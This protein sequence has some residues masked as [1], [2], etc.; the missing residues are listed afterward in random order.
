[1]TFD[2]VWPT[3][4]K[5]PRLLPRGVSPA[6]AVEP[7]PEGIHLWSLDLRDPARS[8]AFRVGANGKTFMP[9]HHASPRRWVPGVHWIYVHRQG[10]GELPASVLR[11]VAAPRQ[12][13]R[14]A[15]QVTLSAD[16]EEPAVA[17]PNPFYTAV[18]A[19]TGRAAW[20][21]APTSEGFDAHLRWV[22]TSSYQH[23]YTPDLVMRGHELGFRVVIQHDDTPIPQPAPPA[24]RRWE[25]AQT[26]DQIRRWLED[27][28]AARSTAPTQQDREAEARRI[29]DTVLLVRTP[30]GLR[31][32]G[33]GRRVE[34][35]DGHNDPWGEDNKWTTRGTDASRDDEVEIVHPPEVPDAPIWRAAALTAR[36]G[37]HAVEPDSFH[38][39]VTQRRLDE[40]ARELGQAL[41]PRRRARRT[42]VYI[43]GGNMLVGTQQSGWPYAL[44]GHDSLVVSMIHMLRTATPA[45]TRL[46]AYPGR[47]AVELAFAHLHRGHGTD[48]ADLLRDL[49][50]IGYFTPDDP[51]GGG[52]QAAAAVPAAGEAD[53]TWEV[54]AW[55]E[56][57]R[58]QMID[59][60]R[61]APANFAVIEQLDFHND[62]HM[63]P[64]APSVVLL[65]D[66]AECERLLARAL[67]AGPPPLERS[68]LQ[69]MQ[70]YFQTDPAP[71]FWRV[72]RD[73]IDRVYEQCRAIGLRVVRCPG[74]FCTLDPIQNAPYPDIYRRANFMNAVP[75]TVVPDT[76]GSVAAGTTFY[77][78]NASSVRSLQRAFAAWL[79][80][81]A[82]GTGVQRVHFLGGEPRWQVAGGLPIS[83]SEWSLHQSGGLDCRESHHSGRRAE[84]DLTRDPTSREAEPPPTALA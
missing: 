84:A 35:I 61:V 48:H 24:R 8:E 76:T 63:R 40:A 26:A 25:S 79:L 52:F 5:D 80:D 47:H 56:A 71:D 74:V 10:P 66:P 65:N 57:T 44:V 3:F 36:R 17:L 23:G 9:A 62:M 67:A 83:W 70:R 73:T 4:K 18:V 58:Q 21:Q 45:S 78:T 81:P 15:V 53:A 72:H 77:M 64:V 46:D 6:P 59:D 55:L 20:P 14:F 31:Q 19:R 75:G 34:D 69:D 33:R 22:Y 82:N 43:E 13:R 29:A 30:I 41:R 37:Y 11:Q 68:A 1:M 54:L 42:R 51:T 27:A 50:R 32:R 12:R 7:L 16:V 38:G 39:A 60:V 28:L 49:R 2:L